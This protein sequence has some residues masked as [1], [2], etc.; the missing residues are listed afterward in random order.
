MT[1]SCHGGL[2]LAQ[3][4]TESLMLKEKVLQPSPVSPT[5]FKSVYLRMVCLHVDLHNF[6]IVT[7]FS[8]IIRP[9]E[10]SMCVSLKSVILP[11]VQQPLSQQLHRPAARCVRV[12]VL[13]FGGYL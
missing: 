1:D 3:T 11:A 2:D 8:H 4:T 13:V 10:Q 5:L 7:F 6:S 12:V 9:N